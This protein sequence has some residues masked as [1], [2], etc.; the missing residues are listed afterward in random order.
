MSWNEYHFITHW[1]VEGTCKEVSDLL[2]DAE[3]LTRW[4]PSVYL[5]VKELAPGEENGVGKSVW[6][7]TKGW[8]PYTLTWHFE[9][10]ASRRPFGWTLEA[11]GDFA[12][13][14][15]WTFEQE[16][17]CVNITYDWRVRADKP[18]L[19]IFSPLLRPIFSA[20]H[21]WA[22]RKGQ[23]SITLEMARLHALTPEARAQIPPPP[24][25]T[26]SF[27][28]KKRKAPI[29]VKPLPATI[30]HGKATRQ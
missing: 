6:L 3:D 20:N 5:E 10:V 19:R 11:S 16:G 30:G 2:S 7:H 4:W 25:P 27:L 29:E 28:L 26:W 8:L 17:D 9:T 13:V 21:H 22:M 12:G 14:G 18:L 24:G 15:I 23:E 1:R